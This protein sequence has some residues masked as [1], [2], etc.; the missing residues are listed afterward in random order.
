MQHYHLLTPEEIPLGVWCLA[1]V[2]RHKHNTYGVEKKL[3]SSP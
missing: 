2:L 3:P 1:Q